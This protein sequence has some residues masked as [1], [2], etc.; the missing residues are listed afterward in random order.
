RCLPNERRP[1]LAGRRGPTSPIATRSS[2]RARGAPS[3]WGGRTSSTASARA[4]RFASA[5]SPRIASGTD[6]TTDARAAGLPASNVDVF[7]TGGDL[8]GAGQ[9]Q[10]GI[11]TLLPSPE[12]QRT[13]QKPLM[14]YVKNRCPDPSQLTAWD[15]A[16]M[17]IEGEML[18]NQACSY[19]AA[20]K[21]KHNVLGAPR[22]NGRG[23]KVVANNNEAGNV[24]ILEAQS[25]TFKYFENEAQARLVDEVHG[26]SLTRTLASARTTDD[27]FSGSGALPCGTPRGRSKPWTRRRFFRKM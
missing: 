7:A 2:L 14:E 9:T 21:F 15:Y 5:P 10:A 16:D 27:P 11:R 3:S 26:G 8:Y 6:P 19:M 23:G 4:R 24:P 12:Y 20:V 22:R 25:L 1:T 13:V 17:T 18:G